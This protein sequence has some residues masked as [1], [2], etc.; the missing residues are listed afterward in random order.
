M[1]SIE[2]IDE[3]IADASLF[4]NFPHKE[5]HH[6]HFSRKRKKISKMFL[7]T[8]LEGTEPVTQ[9]IVWKTSLW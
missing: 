7:K 9:L 3:G 5:L 4:E 1:D 6:Y 2:N 8:F